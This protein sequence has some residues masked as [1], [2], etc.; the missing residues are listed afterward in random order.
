R[1]D[2]A[3]L[4]ARIAAPVLVVVGQGNPITHAQGRR[5][6]DTVR[7]GRHAIVPGGHLAPL[8]DPAA[9][10]AIVDAFLAEDLP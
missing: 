1:F 4:L 5:I 8:D 10:H 6:A 9:F 7:H 2:A 3:P